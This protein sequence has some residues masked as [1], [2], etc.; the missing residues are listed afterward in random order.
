[1]SPVS[2]FKPSGIPKDNSNV[3]SSKAAVAAEPGVSVV[4]VAV[5]VST[6]L[7]LLLAADSAAV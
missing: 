5:K 6:K 7:M 2:P 4:A 3:S 1:V